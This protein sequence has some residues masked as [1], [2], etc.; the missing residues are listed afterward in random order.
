[1]HK[2]SR[3]RDVPSQLSKRVLRLSRE[4]IRTLTTA[5]L[6]LVAGGC[7]TGSWPTL[8]STLQVN[9][10]DKTADTGGGGTC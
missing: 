8:S 2:T 3:R 5:E 6:P 1:M 4:S 7:P 9:G 10:V